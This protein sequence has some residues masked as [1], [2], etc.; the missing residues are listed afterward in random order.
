MSADPTTDFEALRA[1]GRE[2]AEEQI[3]QEAP[4]EALA[5]V[6][7]M[8]G[9]GEVDGTLAAVTEARSRGA[10]WREIASAA[11]LPMRTAISRFERARLRSEG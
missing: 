3:R 11:G 5:R 8:V 6:A 9:F 7:W 10:T 1:T 4:T 2:A